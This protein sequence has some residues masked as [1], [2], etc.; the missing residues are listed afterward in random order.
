MNEKIRT[1]GKQRH[2]EPVVQPTLAAKLA[3]LT[4]VNTQIPGIRRRRA[5]KSFR[6]IDCHGKPIEDTT[7]LSRIKALVIPPAWTHVWI[8]P[9]PRGHLQATGMDS[10]GRKQYRYHAHWRAIRDET[11]YHHMIEFGRALSRIR[12]RTRHDLSVPGLTREKVLAAVVQLLEST[13]IRVGNEEYAAQNGSVGLTTMRNRHVRIAGNTLRF[14][15]RGKSGVKHVI[16]LHDRRLAR[17][18]KSCRDLPGQELFEYIDDRGKRHAI[19]SADVNEY[20]REISGHDFT[21]KDFR[22]WAGTMLAAEELWRS[23]PVTSATQAKK[24]VAKAIETVARQLGNTK[25]VC[26]KCYIHPAIV[27][28]YMNGSLL[29]ALKGNRIA[30]QGR[31]R[32][33]RAA[34]EKALVVFLKPY[35]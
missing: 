26:R 30:E 21:A 27:D 8:C 1:R 18:V 34:A 20:L 6:Y 28:S 32:K 23:G 35:G 9:Q 5:G 29:G 12:K 11:K 22:T 3:G 25:T 33:A 4:Y 14:E 15:F 13:L 7:I 17:I 31:S 19:G 24:N 10:R 16:D 2:I